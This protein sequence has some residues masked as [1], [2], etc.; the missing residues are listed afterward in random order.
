MAMKKII[1]VTLSVVVIIMLL[2]KVNSI[3][4]NIDKYMPLFIGII[5]ALSG[6]VGVW[7]TSY[8]NSKN[9]CDKLNSD[10]KE[11]EKEKI[12]ELRKDIY[13][14]ANDEVVN[15][16]ASIGNLVDPSYKL[17]QAQAI[18]NTFVLTMNRVQLISNVETALKA[19]ELIKFFSEFYNE[20][21][22]DSFE[23]VEI[24][25]MISIKKNFQDKVM[26]DIDR[27]LEMMRINIE[28]NEID[29]IKHKKLEVNFDTLSE[30]NSSYQETINELYMKQNILSKKLLIKILS[31]LPLAQKKAT[32]FM[33]LLR[34][35][36]F[37]VDDLG[38]C[39]NSFDGEMNKSIQDYLNKI[40]DKIQ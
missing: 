34:K 18:F 14:V 6:L 23:M 33:V 38:I 37:G 5:T 40:I 36:I 20:I 12:Y 32:E 16:C 39:L 24:S 29:H 22:V 31:Q 17:D 3:E 28:S 1:T 19:G 8:F 26:A 27:C 21:Q 7:I 35:D 15:L 30:H 2:I 13:L 11:K 9:H 25:N 10:L 4:N